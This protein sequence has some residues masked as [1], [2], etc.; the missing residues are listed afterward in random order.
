MISD[1]FK[2]VEQKIGGMEIVVDKN[3]DYREF[4]NDEGMIRE[5]YKRLKEKGINGVYI[6]IMRGV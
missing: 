6:T 1:Y 5:L 3:I 4:S 2:E